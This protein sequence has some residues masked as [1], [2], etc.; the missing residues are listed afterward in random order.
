MGEKTGKRELNK[1]KK[2]ADI[3]A[4]ASRWF[5]EHGYAATSMS[6]IADEL[7]GSKTTLWS[8]FS[9]KEE[10]FVAVV[11]WQVECFAQDL[12]RTLDF[13]HFSTSTLRKLCLRLIQQLIDGIASPL[14]RLV[15][16][17]GER[18]PEIVEAYYRLGPARLRSRIHR[19]FATHFEEPD[20]SELSR[21]AL[22]ALVGFR[23]EAL[24]NPIRPTASER[25]HFVDMLIA[26][27][28]LDGIEPAGH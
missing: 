15:V 12:E 22:T 5:C 23:S 9:S 4:I 24:V 3:V 28:R 21:L 19:F 20:A 17:E 26:R 27:L 11:D 18:F 7:G 8:H 1:A 25:E 2:R 6:A 13:N 10:L 16:S 14:Y